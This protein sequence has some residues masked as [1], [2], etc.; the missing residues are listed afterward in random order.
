MTDEQRLIEKLQRIE[1]LFAGAATRG[2]REAAAQARERIRARLQEQQQT[3]PPV[4]YT[5]TL[6]DEWSRR[7]LVALMRRY[8]IR[9]YRYRRQR[10]TTV[11]ARVPRRFVTETLWPEFRELNQTLA[12]FL[13]QVTERVISEGIAADASEV[14][15]RAVPSAL[16]IPVENAAG[17][18]FVQD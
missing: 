8:G 15:V 4:E 5:F 13:A 9:P 16:P 6:R 17:S 7:L 3:D 11:M 12:A 2:E 1:A 10:Y 14:E 18:N